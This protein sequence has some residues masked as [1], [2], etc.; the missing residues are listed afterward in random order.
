MRLI[1]LGAALAIALPSAGF[2]Q[3]AVPSTT[4]YMT[5]AGQS[6]LFEIQ[7]G[8]LAQKMSANPAIKNF[9]RQMVADHTKSTEMVSVAA[10]DS[11]MQELPLASLSRDQKAMLAQLK[12]ESGPAFDETYIAQ[13]LK[14]HQDALAL[15]SA[16]AAGGDDPN[17]KAAAGRI[18][19]VVQ[20]HLSMLQAMH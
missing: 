13:Q 6:D 3:A 12:G 17:F 5:M 19:P 4:Q 8:Q 18:V 7:S 16:Y 20:S 2:A 10:K 1:M 9:G 15:Q 14:A 11:G